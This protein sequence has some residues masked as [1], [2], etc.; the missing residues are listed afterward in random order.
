[1]IMLMQLYEMLNGKVMVIV[2]MISS[3]ISCGNHAETFA[4]PRR[5]MNYL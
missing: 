3:F 1:M 4:P 2:E 5:G